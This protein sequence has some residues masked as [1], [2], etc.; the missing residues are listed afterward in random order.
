MAII[1]YNTH[2][3]SPTSFPLAPQPLNPKPAM[4]NDLLLEFQAI[5]KAPKP[6]RAWSKFSP[7]EKPR[8]LCSKWTS[9]GGFREDGD[10]CDSKNCFWTNNDV[11]QEF[12]T[13]LFRDWYCIMFFFSNHF[14][15]FPWVDLT[16][17]KNAA[18]LGNAAKPLP[19]TP[20]PWSMTKAL[21]LQPTHTSAT[22]FFERSKAN[23]TGQVPFDSS[24]ANHQLELLHWKFLLL[25]GKIAFAT[26]FGCVGL[27][28]AMVLFS[29]GGFCVLFSTGVLKT[30]TRKMLFIT[31]VLFS[32]QKKGRQGVKKLPNFKIN[33][34]PILKHPSGASN[35]WERQS[36]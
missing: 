27:F 13:G 34:V 23:G 15:S 26:K 25:R 17:I 19:S 21:V 16:A 20:K 33:L 29:T 32:T 1:E 4:Q 28:S 12:M 7:K 24:Q 9:R 3:C 36:F 22:L 2:I 35:L 6:P 11:T 31:K 8:Y 10:L 18:I 5:T 14:C 30:A